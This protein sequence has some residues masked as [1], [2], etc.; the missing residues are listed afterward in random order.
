M[1]AFG[2]MAGYAGSAIGLDVWCQQQMYGTWEGGEDVGVW[3]GEMVGS[4]CGVEML[5]G[6]IV[7]M[8]NMGMSSAP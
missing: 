7:D 8:D 5:E 6:Y 2:Y 3:G 1:A 4:L